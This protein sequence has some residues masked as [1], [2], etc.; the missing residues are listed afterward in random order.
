MPS[1]LGRGR[2]EDVI[3]LGEDAAA[4]GRGGHAALGHHQA[5]RPAEPERLAAV[6][7]YDRAGAPLRRLLPGGP[8][9]RA[10]ARA[11]TRA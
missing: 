4:V 6:A 5:D 11:A 2:G 7:A 8:F 3:E 10:A 9:T 1:E